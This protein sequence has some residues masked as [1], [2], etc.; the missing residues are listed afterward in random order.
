MTELVREDTGR[1]HFP[2]LTFCAV[3]CLYLPGTLTNNK[4]LQNR[5]TPAFMAGPSQS[6]LALLLVPANRQAC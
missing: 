1:F 3:L 6:D 5:R 2:R 4:D